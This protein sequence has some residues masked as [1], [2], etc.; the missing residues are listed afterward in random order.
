MRL[1][2][3]E[4][5][6]FS[7]KE[8]RDDEVPPYAILSHTWLPKKK[9][10]GKEA[11]D[12]EEEE[13]EQEPTYEDL[14]DGT[15]KNKPGYKKIQFC[16]EQA[17]RDDLKYFWVDTC[18][19]N[20]TN[21]AEL[22]Y[23]IN[24]MFRWYRNATRCYVYLS[25]VHSPPPDT[26]EFNPQ[27]WDSDFWRSR[28]FTRGWTLQE[29]LAPQSVEF[30]SRECVRLGDKFSLSKQISEITGVD[31]SAIQGAPLCQFSEDERLLWMER[32][33]TTLEADRVYALLGILDVKLPLFKDTEVA[34]AF[35]RLLEVI[36]KRKKCM[37][38]LYSSD[39][40]DD[41]KRI[42]DTKGGLLNDSYCWILQNPEFIQWRST[43]Q[44]PLL[45]IKGD[46]G[47]GKTML[48]C[49]IINELNKPINNTTLLSYFFCQATDSRIN[50]ATA[51][52]R[53]LLYMLVKQQPSLVS[54]VRKKYDDAGKSLFED[55][56]AWIALCEIF[57]S[58]FKDLSS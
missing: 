56:N 8:F 55:V 4:A 42:E 31:V 40:R 36:D 23:A 20:K 14:M 58:I 25:D 37:Q 48:L 46:P 57:T 21:Y 45:W 54:H 17:R 18:C 11:W 27:S 32:R 34:T 50:N 30:F 15:G 49:G 16:G 12:E 35:D 39:P 38:D 53:G 52:L 10:G 43:W 19:I 9:K 5:G 3:G 41:K 2:Q 22:Q 13:E 24:S 26:T 28:W 44:N 7:F 33:Q 29:L 47:K 1:L 6:S 51:V